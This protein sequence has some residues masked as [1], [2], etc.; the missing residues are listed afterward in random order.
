MVDGVWRALLLRRL[1]PP[2]PPDEP[3]LAGDTS[4]LC[5]VHT[6]ILHFFAI[7]SGRKWLQTVGSTSPRACSFFVVD[8][9]HVFFSIFAIDFGFAIHCVSVSSTLVG[10]VQSSV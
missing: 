7:F 8:F 5:P 4:Y 6:L 9:G 2:C 1:D 3:P 10:I